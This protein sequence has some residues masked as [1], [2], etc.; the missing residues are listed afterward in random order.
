VILKIKL[1]LW[2]GA[3]GLI[4]AVSLLYAVS[5]FSAPL[6]IG[7]IC[8]TGPDSIFCSPQLLGAQ[9]VL[10]TLSSKSNP[11]VYK[12]IYLNKYETMVEEEVKQ[13]SAV[14][15][16]SLTSFNPNYI[17]TI[18]NAAF[19][20]VGLIYQSE[21]TEVPTIFSGL[22]LPFLNYGEDLEDWD[23]YGVKQVWDLTILKKLLDITNL[24]MKKVYLLHDSSPF[25]FYIY[26]NID[27]ELRRVGITKIEEVVIEDNNALN[28]LI[29]DKNKDTS[30]HIYFSC[31]VR[32]SNLSTGGTVTTDEIHR[33]IVLL[34]KKHVEIG[35]NVLLTHPFV[36]LSLSVGPDPFKMGGTAGQMVVN[37]FKYGTTPVLGSTDTIIS[38]N[39]S[40]MVSLGLR[41]EYKKGIKY[42]N[43]IH[44]N[45]E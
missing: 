34:N 41:E 39:S 10:Y 29:I 9:E 30:V 27:T 15:L 7:F 23:M 16:S 33:R 13:V 4:Y 35:A 37:H 8:S 26:K 14:A 17:L 21:H 12:V 44:I 11:L 40:R 42:F 18:G 28:K 6:K 19:Q 22:N 32:I 24:S 5:S 3:R 36:G 1:S 38:V 25:S 20:Y 43:K 2:V 31:L 45:Y